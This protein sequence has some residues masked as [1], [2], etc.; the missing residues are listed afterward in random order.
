MDPNVLRGYVSEAI[1]AA[2]EL[3]VRITFN[4]RLFTLDVD[5]EKLER[6]SRFRPRATEYPFPRRPSFDP[7]YWDENGFEK[8][9]ETDIR[10]SVRVMANQ[11]C[12]KP[13]SFA[14]VDYKGKFGTCNHMMYPENL[15]MG[16]LAIQD[17]ASIWNAAP[18]QECRR[19]LRMARPSDARCQWCFQHRTAD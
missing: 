8:L 3:D 11:R 14:Y 19:Q 2:L 16:D 12:F 1:D 6:A 13:F 7:A 17:T 4:D 10:E 15:E 18:Y 5:A 9:I